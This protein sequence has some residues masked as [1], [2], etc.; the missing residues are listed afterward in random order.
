MSDP[1]SDVL[2]RRVLAY[3]LDLL[4][5][6]LISAV[7]GLVFTL[8]TIFSLGLLGVL[9]YVLPAV[10][11][12]YGALTIGG[13]RSATW[14]MRILAIQVLRTDRGRPDFAQALVF[15]LL[16]YATVALTSWLILLV[17]LV[18]PRKRALHDLLSGVV[19]VRADLP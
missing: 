8:L 7:L 13:P 12:L 9:F 4:F 15:S 17:A 6:A 2:L 5:V 3:L 16:F 18:M 19:V 10:G 1:F 11:V 14:G